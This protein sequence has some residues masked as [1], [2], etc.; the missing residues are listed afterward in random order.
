MAGGNFWL[1][2]TAPSLASF[3][4]WSRFAAAWLGS[5]TR[6]LVPA[7]SAGRRVGNLW[8]RAGGGCLGFAGS[9]GFTPAPLW[10]ETLVCKEP[11]LWVA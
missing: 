7:R 1:P 8:E 2:F 6:T 5:W 4:K 9:A 3:S 10:D 11:Y